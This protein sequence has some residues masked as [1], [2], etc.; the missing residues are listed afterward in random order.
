MIPL[1]LL[2]TLFFVGIFVEFFTN[3]FNVIMIAIFVLVGLVVGMLWRPSFANRVF[4]LVPRDNR[5]YELP[6]Q[7]ETACSLHC[8]K[9]RGL[10][11]QRFLKH[12]GGFTGRIGRI[13]KRPSTIHLGIEGTAYTKSV[14]NPKVKAT[15]EESIRSIWGDEFY[16]QVPE[17]QRKLIEDSTINVTVDVDD[18][19]TPVDPETGKPYRPINEQDIK[20]EEDQSCWKT[21]WKGRALTERGQ[22]IDKI[23]IG[24]AGAGMM[25]LALLLLGYIQTG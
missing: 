8:K 25:L 21:F 7:T 22:W 14:K 15:L 3:V 5:F 6:V 19:L 18:V 23:V 11:L 12:A 17:E 24:L 13:L 4:K 9:V 2:T 1:N 10:P 16:E 20:K